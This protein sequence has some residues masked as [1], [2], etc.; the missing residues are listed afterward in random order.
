MG[1]FDLFKKD[2]NSQ[3]NHIMLRGKVDCKEIYL[4]NDIINQLKHKYISFD[5]ETTGLDPIQDR[6]IEIGAVLFENRTPVS[7]FGTL[8]NSNKEISS[9][10]MRV[11]NISNEMVNDSPLESEVYPKFI[12]FLD[13]AL[14]GKVIICA[15]NARFDISFLKNTLERLGYNGTIVYIDTL[16]ISRDI[17]SLENYKQSTVAEYFN[18]INKDAHRAVSDAEVCGE[19]LNNFLDYEIKEKI[20]KNEQRNIIELDQYEKIVLSYILNLIEDN[21][22][23]SEYLS[24][25]KNSGG[26]IDVCCLYKFLK[27]KFSKKG[28]YIIIPSIYKKDM[29]LPFEICNTSEGGSDYIRVYYKNLDELKILDNIFVKEYLNSY[30]SM[31]DYIDGSSR[32]EQNALNEISNMYQL[33]SAEAKQILNEELLNNVLNNYC[34]DFSIE[35]KVAREDITIKPVNDRVSLNDIKNFNNWEK[36]FDAGYKYWENGE[37]LR[38]SGNYHEAIKQYD[39]SRYNGYESVVLYDSYAMAYHQLK[40]YDNEIDI[41]DEGINRLSEKYNISSLYSRRDKAVQILYKQNIKE[42]EFIEKQKLKEEQKRLKE[43]Q[44]EKEKLEKAEQRKN[45]PTIPSTARAILQLDD[46]GNILNLYPTI[47][48]AVRQ[49]GINSKSIRDAAN[50]VQKHAGGYCWKYKDVTDN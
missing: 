7:K 2:N 24:A 16:S 9:E 36:G 33:S 14:S 26:Y 10:A 20:N 15:H 25:R 1:I 45:N 22:Y 4:N 6:I 29:S 3:N 35:K 40:D 23:S 19:I 42:T 21:G 38:K 49:T 11:N 27:Y 13:E 47:A 5:I 32:R 37:N 28:K 34:S 39:L 12:S 8:V 43:E 17:L 44:K 31:N 18:I 48:E 46:D 30:N 41:L 50:G